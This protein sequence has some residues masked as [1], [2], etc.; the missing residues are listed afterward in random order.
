[1][2]CS[3]EV[4]IHWLRK[5][6]LPPARM[7]V[8][9]DDLDLPFGALRLKPSG[10]AGGHHGMESIIERLGGDFPRVRIGIADQTIPKARQV[11]Y[12]LSP[13]ALDR[14]D[15]LAAAAALAAE[16]VRES[17]SSGWAKAMSLYNRSELPGA[18]GD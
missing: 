15:V 9:Y 11:D 14:W 8:I 13:L 10:G 2:N 6:G 1:M 12:L 5:L 3:G 16:A 4:V 7:V 17:L 18:D